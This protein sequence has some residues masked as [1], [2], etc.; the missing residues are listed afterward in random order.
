MVPRNRPSTHHRLQLR[1]GRHPPRR[2]V[3]AA[4]VSPDPDFVSGC[5]PAMRRWSR[6]AEA[7]SRKARVPSPVRS[8]RGR[9]ILPWTSRR[10]ALDSRTQRGIQ[11]AKGTPGTHD[12][13]I[14]HRL[15]TV[16]GADGSSSSTTAASSTRHPRNASARAAYIPTCDPPEGIDSIAKPCGPV[17]DA[18]ER[19]RLSLGSRDSGLE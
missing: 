9:P 6:R 13:V 18:K 17:E 8:S 4:A 10:S 5:R 2:R 7:S 1:Y 3:I 19:S 11:V 15:S 14:A 12:D 16:V